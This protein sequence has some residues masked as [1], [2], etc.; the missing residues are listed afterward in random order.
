[1]VHRLGGVSLG[2]MWGVSSV[3]FYGCSVVRF[4]FNLLQVDSGSSARRVSMSGRY[5][6]N[7]AMWFGVSLRPCFYSL[8]VIKR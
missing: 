3:G 7:M 4:C 2:E 6:S 1:M 5:G 8:Q